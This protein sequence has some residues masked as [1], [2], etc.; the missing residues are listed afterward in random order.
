MLM[1]VYFTGQP[2]ETL[3][4]YSHAAGEEDADEGHREG[5]STEDGKYS[6]TNHFHLLY[7]GSGFNLSKTYQ[8]PSSL[9][10]GLMILK[11]HILQYKPM[12]RYT[13]SILTMMQQKTVKGESHIG[14]GRQAL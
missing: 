3:Q 8:F 12:R 9:Q 14:I 11:A 2:D 7:R 6:W 4:L 5:Q 1:D 13:D 10:L